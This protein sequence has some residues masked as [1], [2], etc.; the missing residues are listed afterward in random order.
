MGAASGDGALVS[1]FSLDVP[2]MDDS[3]SEESDASFVQRRRT[4]DDNDVDVD[5]VAVDEDL[6]NDDP[7]GSI[8]DD[9][10]ISEDDEQSETDP[11]DDD[12]PCPDLRV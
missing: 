8:A 3:V 4:S 9:T 12:Q 5:V 6:T 7:D 11:A 10:S 1:M 2:S